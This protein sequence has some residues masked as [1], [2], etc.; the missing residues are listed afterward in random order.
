MAPRKKN[1]ET[2]V[3]K[4]EVQKNT[5]RKSA[6]KNNE[7]VAESSSEP[8]ERSKAR[9]HKN[10]D[11]KNNEASQANPGGFTAEMLIALGKQLEEEERA[12]ENIELSVDAA[13][14]YVESFED[15]EVFNEVEDEIAYVNEDTND[16]DAPIAEQGVE[17]AGQVF[18][19]KDMNFVV[20]GET[21]DSILAISLNILD[22][23]MRF[24]D[25][26]DKGSNDWKKSSLR[27]KLNNEYINKF[28]KNDLLPIVSDLTADT[29]EDDYGTC[30][31]YIT[32]PS[33]NMFRKFHKIIPSYP[34]WVWSLTPWAIE[35]GTLS[36][37]GARTNAKTIYSEQVNRELG[38]AIV[39]KF[40]RIAVG[41]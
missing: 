40:K 28:D 15:V 22:T 27:K 17:M 31:D 12:K 3:E 18:K 19:Y 25:N 41:L 32:I 39:C 38:V 24:A 35:Y 36:A 5:S 14:D 29:G 6:K 37:A 11:V 30:E 10:N 26:A 34:G 4:V 20:L 13:E 9:T 23:K 16:N 8:A 7:N 1:V 2:K 33:D 21:S